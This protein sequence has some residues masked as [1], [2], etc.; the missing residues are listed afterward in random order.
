[1]EWSAAV[2]G[3]GLCSI[4]REAWANGRSWLRQRCVTGNVATAEAD[5]FFPLVGDVGAGRVEAF[6]P[7]RVLSD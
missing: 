5:I 6:L 4:L 1:M 3:C 2:G 7:T